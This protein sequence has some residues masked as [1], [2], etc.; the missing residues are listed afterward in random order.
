MQFR[1]TRMAVIVVGIAVATTACGKYSLSSIR[2]LKSFKDG[3]ELYAKGDYPG[4]AAEFQD[5]IAHNPEFG[6]SYFY[7]GNSFDNMYRATRAGDAENDALLPRAAENYRLATDKLEGSTEPQAAQIRKLSFEYLIAVYGTDKLDDFSQA[8]PAARALIAYEPNEPGN[9]QLLGRLYEGQGD[10]EQAEAMFLEAIQVQPDSPLSYQLLAHFYNRQGEFDKTMEA[11]QQRAELE[12]N[13]P[14]AWHTMGTFYY[15]K[16]YQ[17][18]S[19][20]RPQAIA[21][22]ESGVTAEDMALDLNPDYYEAVTYKSM[23]LA[24]RAS[25]ETSRAVQEKYLAE[26]AVLQ[27]RAVEIQNKQGSAVAVPEAN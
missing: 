13:N 10:I 27:E 19:V 3:A 16:V 20:E 14:E 21:Y 23:L 22:I 4:A 5:S 8:E 1:L 25:K 6:F 11:F 2:S 18:Q 7:L 9:Y 17:D 15:D 26:A 12:P 24:L